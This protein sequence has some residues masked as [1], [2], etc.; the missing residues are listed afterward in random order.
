MLAKGTPDAR[1]IRQIV[2]TASPRKAFPGVSQAVPSKSLKSKGF[3]SQML[4][5]KKF[6]LRF[7]LPQGS[8]PQFVHGVELIPYGFYTNNSVHKQA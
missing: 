2:S 6:S 8:G 3:S 5:P 4:P 1:Q 7:S